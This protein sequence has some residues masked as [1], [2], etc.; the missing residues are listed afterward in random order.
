MGA[1][2]QEKG[3]ENKKESYTPRF[4]PCLGK[5]FKINSTPSDF[6]KSS[7]PNKSMNG[8]GVLSHTSGNSRHID[9]KE[10]GREGKRSY[11]QQAKPLA[12][13]QLEVDPVVL[14]WRDAD[15]GARDLTV[16]Y[17]KK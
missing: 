5:G 4:V 8:R 17:G 3:Q 2:K 13:I 6:S 9:G 1:D 16:V 15:L 14:I 7:G 10:K 11:F 12:S